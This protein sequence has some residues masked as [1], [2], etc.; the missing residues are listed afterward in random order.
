MLLGA[1]AGPV[2]ALFQWRELRHHLAGA[3]GWMAA[4]AAA[5]ALAMPLVFLAVDAATVGTSLA[6]KRPPPS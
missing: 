4:N 3:G 2:L 6:S 5:W 1:V